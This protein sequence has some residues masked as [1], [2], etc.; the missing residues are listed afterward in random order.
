MKRNRWIFPVAVTAVAIA[1]ITVAQDR[2]L[3]E[4]YKAAYLTAFIV[5]L[6]SLLMIVWFAAFSDLSRRTR[7]GG[8]IVVA[9]VA[10]AGVIFLKLTTRVDGTVSG[11]GVPRLVWKW[12]P[13]AGEN[14][15]E[16]PAVTPG[17]AIH[18][19]LAN[20]APMDFPEFLGPGRQNAITGVGLSRDWSTPPRKLWRQ[21]IGLGWGSF[22][23]VGPFAVTQEQRGS[24]EV[25]VCY[26][27]ATGKVCWLHSNPN[28]RFTEW[29]GGDGPRATPT[30][31][32]GRVYATGAT[33][34]LDCLD[35]ATG[36]VIWSH[37]VLE[38]TSS[39]NLT[40]GKTCSP[41]VTD[42]LV[43]VTGGEGGPALL[44]LHKQDGASAWKAGGETP[45][46]ASPMLATLGG[47][48]QVVTINSQSAAGYAL[49]DGQPLWRFAWSGGMPKV[50]QTVPLDH[51]RVL[52]SAGYGLGTLVL[53]VSSAPDGKQSVRTLWESRS[54]K[55]KMSNVVVHQNFVYGLD[56]GILTCLNLETGKRM[57]RGDSY[58]FGQLLGV[59]DL[60]LIQAESGEVALVEAN[61]T[62][63]RE[64]ARFPAISGK[65][66]NNPALSGHRLL[67]RNDHEA[68]CYDLP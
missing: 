34:I 58:G 61:P 8:L 15:V 56:D 59:D 23:I 24:T 49:A 43:I 50:P 38:E 17:S 29:Q 33:G 28:A 37:D 10:V 32:G 42:E 60:L 7:L 44:A 51:D 35:G 57:W 48:Q 67:V 46:Y 25:I 45:G 53:Q 18:V 9:G 27:T 36:R 11:V 31:T 22:A 41:L 62:A 54:L 4:S 3:L 2:L 19:D 21:P 68:A 52:I 5:L 20:T 1:A 66:W 65:T 12:T 64:L 14:T 6:V 16:L 63:Y 40:Y 30:I 26:E 47:V 13:R 55:P 39:H